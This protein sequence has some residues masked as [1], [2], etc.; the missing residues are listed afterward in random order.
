MSSSMHAGY[1]LWITETLS[2]SIYFISFI[3]FTLYY[4]YIYNIVY[5]HW[6]G[7]NSS[8]RGRWQDRNLEPKETLVDG[9]EVEKRRAIDK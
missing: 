9:S 8:N 4:I 6:I 2:A 5:T 7:K 1:W 3:L